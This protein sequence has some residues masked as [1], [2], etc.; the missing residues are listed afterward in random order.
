[1]GFLND[2]DVSFPGLDRHRIGDRTFPRRL[3]GRY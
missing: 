3:P 2:G 1:M